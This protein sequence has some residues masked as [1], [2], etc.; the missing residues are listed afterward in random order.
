MSFW[1]ERTKEVAESRDRLKIEPEGLFATSK[2][3]HEAFCEVVRERVET[4]EHR[5]TQEAGR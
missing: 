5:L 1:V 2:A 4:E 3:A